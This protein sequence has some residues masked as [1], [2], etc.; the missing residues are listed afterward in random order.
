MREDGNLD[1]LI[2]AALGTYAEADSDLERRVLA[3]IACQRTPAWRK[4]PLGWVSALAAVACLLLAVALMHRGAA[5]APVADR[6]NVPALPQAPVMSE[7]PIASRIPQRSSRSAHHRPTENAAGRSLAIRLLKQ[8]I[9]PMPRPLS[10]E[11]QVLAEFVARAP[12]AERESLI[13]AQEHS[14]EP[15]AIAAIRIEPIQIPPLELPEAGKD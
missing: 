8:E 13:E 1:R 12:E 10:P 15:I 2:D 5:R 11:E 14:D 9:F 3:R 6:R 4:G 7:A